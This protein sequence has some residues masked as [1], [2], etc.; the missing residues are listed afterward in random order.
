MVFLIL[1]ESGPEAWSLLET[2]K[3]EEICASPSYF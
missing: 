3:G 2:V 1:L